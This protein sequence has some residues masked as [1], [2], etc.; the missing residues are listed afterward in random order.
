MCYFIT[1]GVP[2]KHAAQISEAFGRGFQL[3][4][5]ANASILSPDS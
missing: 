2:E 3:F 1:I 4:P 5:T